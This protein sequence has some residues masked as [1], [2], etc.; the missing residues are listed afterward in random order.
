MVKSDFF[1]NGYANGDHSLSYDEDGWFKTGDIAYFDDEFCFY[2]VDRIKDLLKVKNFQIAPS[3]IE[4]IVCS[5]P[6]VK[7]AA[8][9]S[10]ATDADG[11]IPV[12]CVVLNKDCEKTKEEDIKAFVDQHADSLRK[13]RGGVKFYK[14]LPSTITGK[15]SRRALRDLLKPTNNFISL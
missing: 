5:H 3:S 15:I 4:C 8:V 14:S 12:A 9:V 11:D 2:I 13:L 6:S 7:C 10:T 1:M